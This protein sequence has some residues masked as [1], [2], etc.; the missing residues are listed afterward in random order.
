MGVFRTL[1]F[2]GVS[3]G[4]LGLVCPGISTAADDDT[5]SGT[6]E[7]EAK[8]LRERGLVLFKR[9]EYAESVAALQK[10]LARQRTA[11]AMAQ[12]ASALN[13]LGRYDEALR[14]YETVLIEFPNASERLRKTVQVEMDDLV[15]KVGTISVAGDVIAGA[16]LLIDSRDVGALP[17]DGPVRVL[18]GVHEVRA[19]KPGFTPI[20]AS[21][22]V[23]AGKPSVAKLV[24]RERQA[25]LDIHEK[26]NWVMHVEIDGQDVG[27]TPLTKI[28]NAG[29]HRIRLVGFMRPEALLACETPDTAVDVGARMESE[30]KTVQLELF[31]SRSVEL[32]ADDVDAALRVESTPP[33]ATLWI[34]GR[35][36]GTTP[37]LGRLPLGQ[38]TL[39]LRHKGYYEA[40][41]VVTMERRNRRDVSVLL[42]HEPD[43][44]AEKRTA[45]NAKIGAGI[46]YGIGAVGLGLF[47]ISGGLFLQNANRLETN[48]PAKRCPSTES[49]T[50]Q[51]VDT[52][53]TWSTVGLVFAGVGISAG[54][55]MLWFTRP[56]DHKRPGA[57]MVSASFGIGGATLSGRF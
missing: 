48:C 52:F 31:E 9:K 20:K 29:E 10:A 57:P 56:V 32:S 45:R 8:A 36:A 11:G 53:G 14:W 13:A 19:E 35:E 44:E 47:A 41:Q 3:V 4:V 22:E 40:K 38:R 24:A 23:S 21:V 5:T 30:E 1:C 25:K 51:D 49:T 16:R 46:A 50:L 34:D 18:A 27:L 39:E 37:W 2:M 7:A 33:G 28:V 12:M 17:L 54:T 26:H 6:V 42:E 15:A 55:T 43:L